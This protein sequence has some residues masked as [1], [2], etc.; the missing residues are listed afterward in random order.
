MANAYTRALGTPIPQTQ[1]ADPTQVLNNAGGYTFA[2]SDEVRLNRFLTLGTVGGTYYTNEPTL[3]KENIDFLIP[4]IQNKEQVVIDIVREI[5]T[6]GRAFRNSPAI[7]VTAALFHYGKLKPLSLVTDVCR[8]GTHIYE[9]AQYIELFGGWGRAKRDAVA[10]WY[11]SKPVDKLA[12]DA[13]KYRQRDGW[14]HRDLLRLSHARGVQPDVGRFI[15]GQPARAEAEEIPVI[16]GFKEAQAC[17]SVS[18]VLGIL[19]RFPML[20]WET[21]PTQFL[22]EPAVWKKLFHNGA[23]N[24]QALVRNITRLARIGAFNDMVFTREVAD[25]LVDEK[26]IE[27]TRLHPFQYLLASGIHEHGQFKRNEAYSR[28]IKDWE[29]NPTIMAALNDGFYK[30]FEYVEPANKRTMIA[31]DVSG[32]MSSSMAGIPLRACQITAAMSMTIARTEPWYQIMGFA[33][34]DF[35]NLGIDPSMS[36]NSIMSKVVV[37]NF[38]STDC[39]LPMRYALQRGIEVDTF[40]VMTD[41]ETY[42]GPVHPH[43]ALQQ[44]RKGTGIDAKMVV[45]STTPTNFSIADPKDAGMLDI[46]GADSNLPKLITEFSAGRI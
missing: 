25:R 14:T 5:S 17:D 28:L 23:L 35:R 40:I 11:T 21:L 12:Y 46:C 19:E 9:F 2:V 32:S 7:F 22:T 38:G 4:M 33:N 27:R 34:N 37:S 6:S 13:V 24:G 26:M 42:V 45:V 29:T 18:S 44:Y 10:N 8:I 1:K 39:G 16:A 43:V 31:L 36:L 15:L 20:P 3:T 30:A 41:N